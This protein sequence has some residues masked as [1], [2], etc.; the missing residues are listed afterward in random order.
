M[1]YARGFSIIEL[2]IVVVIIGIVA[3]IAIPNLL[4]SRRA[5]NEASAMA[6]LRVLHGATMTYSVSMGS[7]N[8][9]GLANTVGI[10][11]LT[12]L[13]NAQLIDPA[14]ATG[15]K[16]SYAFVGDRSPAAGA[17]PATFYFAANP[18]GSGLAIG[19]SRR[20]GIATEG[21]LKYDSTAANLSVPFDATSL[22]SAIALEVNY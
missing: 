21:V 13:Y 5:A 6:S 19:G 22:S 20:L 4:S 15:F 10:S 2:L 12:D 8:F 3:A 9:A 7:G 17:L 11:S 18:T 14:L 16:A 1:R